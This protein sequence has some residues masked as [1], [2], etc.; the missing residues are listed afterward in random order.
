MTAIGTQRKKGPLEFEFDSSVSPIT[1]L[2]RKDEF[3][4]KSVNFPDECSDFSELKGASSTE[5]D[6][7]RHRFEKSSMRVRAGAPGRHRD[8]SPFHSAI[9]DPVERRA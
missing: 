2:V 4:Q 8:M 7:S 9:L 5:R 3:P 1:K 6:L